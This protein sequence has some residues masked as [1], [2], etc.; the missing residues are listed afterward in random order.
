METFPKDLEPAILYRQQLA[1]TWAGTPITAVNGKSLGLAWFLCIWGDSSVA[2]TLNK[3]TNWGSVSHLHGRNKLLKFNHQ[4][5][6]TYWQC[7][8]ILVLSLAIACSV[9][10]YKRATIFLDLLFCC[11]SLQASRF[12]RIFILLSYGKCRDLFQS[13]EWW[14]R[15]GIRP[16]YTVS[17]RDLW[18]LSNTHHM[19]TLIILRLT[20][21]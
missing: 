8:E 18:R 14:D 7:L 5:K 6:E 11:F 21:H 19:N 3:D 1:K 16:Q 4:F 9:F 10:Q 2:G 15:D 20:L 12:S 17:N 13:S